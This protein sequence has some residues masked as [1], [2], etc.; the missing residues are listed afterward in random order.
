MSFAF[1]ALLG[2]LPVGLSTFNKSV[3]A[4]TESQIAQSILTQARQT[5]FSDLVAF[6]TVDGKFDFD[7]QGKQTDDAANRI[8][9][10]KVTIYPYDTLTVGAQPVESSNLSQMN[11][12]VVKIVV[13]KISAP[14]VKRTISAYV[15]NNGI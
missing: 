6:S 15:A 8:Y 11:G 13:S 1:V 3:D 9:F 5:K 10:A 14:K 7:E 12:A 4:A 2:M